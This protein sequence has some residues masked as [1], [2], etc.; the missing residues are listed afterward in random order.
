MMR[1]VSEL[2][3]PSSQLPNESRNDKK[4][5]V[6]LGKVQKGNRNMSVL[7][8]YMNGANVKSNTSEFLDVFDPSTQQALCK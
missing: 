1:T 6:E 5:K 3:I 4:T 7:P 2:L 8:L